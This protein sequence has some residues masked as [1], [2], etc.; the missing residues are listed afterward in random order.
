M[1]TIPF[2]SDP[3]IAQ[4]R[5]AVDLFNGQRGGYFIEAGACDGVGASNTF[6][7]EQSFGWNGICVEPNDEFFAGLARNRKCAVENVCIGDTRGPVRF[8][9][10]EYYGGIEESLNEGHFD[11][12]KHGAVIEKQCVLLEDLLIKHNAPKVIDYISLDLEGGEL[13]VLKSFPFERYTVRAMTI[14]LGSPHIQEFVESMGFEL[15]TNR[16][17]DPSVVWEL[18]FVNANVGH[19]A[20]EAVSTMLSSM[21]RPS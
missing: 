12:Y 3:K 14:E 8:R 18:H 21:N 11:D 1:T 4:D 2:Y 15:V 10:A 19:F 17:S 16:F 13:A 7:L 9:S 6:T 20:G 5:W